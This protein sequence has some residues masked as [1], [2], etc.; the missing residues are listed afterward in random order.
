MPRGQ[1]NNNAAVYVRDAGKD[2]GAGADFTGAPFCKLQEDSRFD[3]SLWICFHILPV[4]AIY[5]IY[6]L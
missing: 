3:L 5:I 6:L 4:I 2:S 1:N